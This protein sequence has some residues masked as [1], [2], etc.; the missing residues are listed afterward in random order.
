MTSILNR[1]ASLLAIGRVSRFDGVQFTRW[2]EGMLRPEVAYVM[3]HAD[4]VAMGAPSAL[5]VTA[6]PGDR[7][8]GVE[9]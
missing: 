9:S 6:E 8:S 7:L 5:T 1:S 4:W 2:D 3:E